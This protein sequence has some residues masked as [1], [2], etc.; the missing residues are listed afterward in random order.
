MTAVASTHLAAPINYFAPALE[1]PKPQQNKISAAP[2]SSYDSYLLYLE[3]KN[4]YQVIPVFDPEYNYLGNSERLYNQAS[5]AL[6]YQRTVPEAFYAEI[7]TYQ[8]RNL[9]ALYGAH[10]N[11]EHIRN[12]AR[13][14]GAERP[15]NRPEEWLFI[16]EGVTPYSY[17][18]TSYP[19]I[20]YAAQSA[21]AWDIPAVNIIPYYNDWQVFSELAAQVGSEK[22]IFY[23]VM[24]A[25]QTGDIPFVPGKGYDNELITQTIVKYILFCS[26]QNIPFNIDRL[27]ALFP[28]NDAKYEQTAAEC[29]DIHHGIRNR[30]AREN[31]DKLLQKYPERKNILVYC[32]QEH[33]SVFGE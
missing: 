27:N 15:M 12:M 17:L 30:I 22:A 11:P 2:Q 7:M 33:I 28:I 3:D 8:D 5:D 6:L 19:E 21:K 23:L 18:G 1:K 13:I 20:E 14:F 10:F 25:M 16:I 24:F 29:W 32:G 4:K 26:E 9:F 31:L